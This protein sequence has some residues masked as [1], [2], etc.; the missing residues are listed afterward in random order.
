MNDMQ[1]L[2]D[3]HAL[4]DIRL[5]VHWATQ[6]LSAVADARLPKAADDSHS[7][8]G[9]EAALPGLVGRL[10]PDGQ[11]FGLRLSDPALVKRDVRGEVIDAMPLDRR[12]LEGAF[13]WINAQ[14]GEG[15]E[16]RARDYDM[17]AHPVM[18]GTPFQFADQ[19]S[20]GAI[21]AWCD[22]AQTTLTPCAD[23]HPNTGEVRLWPHHLD[24]GTLVLL[25]EGDDPSRAPCVGIG[26]SLGDG[27]Y[28]QPYFYVNPYGLDPAP[29]S[30][31]DLPHG[32]FWTEHWTGGVLLGE[33]VMDHGIDSAAD[34]LAQTV[35]LC[36]GLLRRTQS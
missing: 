24:F 33:S 3:P 34:F 16:A 2:G 1:R 17:P 26:M 14:A 30:L 20:L 36:V 31:P 28:D 11:Q 27:T 19:T 21:D 29:D 9:Y 22:L 13:A 10:S 23:A 18:T 15:P 6:T 12:T 8:L 7:N 5:Q 25:N 4:R 32:G 35:D